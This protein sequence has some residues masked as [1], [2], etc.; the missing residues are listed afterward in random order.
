MKLLLWACILCAVLAKKRFH[1]LVSGVQHSD[2][3][4]LS[5]MLWSPQDYSGNHYPVSPS[6]T[7]PYPISDIDFVPP[8]RP[9]KKKAPN[10]LGNPDPDTGTP[11]YSWVLPSP[12]APLYRIPSFP[13]TTWLS[14]S[15]QKPSHFVPPASRME[16]PFSTFNAPMPMP[17]EPYVATPRTT[18]TT[19]PPNPKLI[20]VEPGPIEPDEAEPAAAE[21]QPSTSP[22]K[23]V[24]E[25]WPHV[26]SSNE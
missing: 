7:I 8:F 21:P 14:P 5:V 15:P 20:A 18:P 6:L 19:S 23:V 24:L 3:T 12:G 25:T 16:G 13:L 9:S 2:S 26:I 4:S 11:P 17:A 1:F 22:D 10:Y